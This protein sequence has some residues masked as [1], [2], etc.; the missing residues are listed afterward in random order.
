MVHGSYTTDV[1]KYT[2]TINTA[3]HI[4]WLHQLQEG[5]LVSCTGT[6]MYRIHPHIPTCTVSLSLSLSLVLHSY[7]YLALKNAVL[8]V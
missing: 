3:K 7:P 6:I 2:L 5:A 1:V 8:A 4:A